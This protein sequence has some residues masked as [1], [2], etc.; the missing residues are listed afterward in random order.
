MNRFNK[1]RSCIGIT[2]R[3]IPEK[4]YG[5]PM[6]ICRLAKIFFNVNILST[7]RMF[8]TAINVWGQSQWPR[9]L[10]HRS[11]TSRLLGLRV[12]IPPGGMNVCLSVSVVYCQVEISALG[13]SLVQRIPIDWGVSECECEASI[14]RRPWP[15]MGCFTIGEKIIL[16]EMIACL[17]CLVGV[18]VLLSIVRWQ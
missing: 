2:L 3:W 9:G 13:W 8:Q 14:K 17:I 16:W 4:L 10:R 18:W 5:R 7:R 6:G 15:T 11:A 12:R 1:P